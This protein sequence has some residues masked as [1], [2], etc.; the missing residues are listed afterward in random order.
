MSQKVIKQLLAIMLGMAMIFSM[1][2][3]RENSGKTED[4][5]KTEDSA[6]G[7]T[8][9]DKETDGNG[10]QDT[11]G[12]T[13]DKTTNGGE[14]DTDGEKQIMKEWDLDAV[15]ANIMM[16]TV[17]YSHGVILQ[18]EKYPCW[19]TVAMN[20]DT[21]EIKGMVRFD[22]RVYIDGDS[23]MIAYLGGGE[24]ARACTSADYDL[25]YIYTV[26]VDATVNIEITSRVFSEKSDG[27]KVYAY[28]NDP[29]NYLVKETLVKP[30]DM[31]QQFIN[32]LEVKKGDKLY[33]GYNPNE[34]SN[35]DEG[36]FYIKLIYIDV[37]N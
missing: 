26:P 29:S 21:G 31:N 27:F 35:E 12:D 9:A 17:S 32:M 23:E 4:E 7:E 14:T 36:N 22:D 10:E 6:D 1:A 33:F 13:D 24:A 15:A 2:A 19:D 3:C 20:R 11:D 18:P 34:S 8:D 37:A 5:Q 30:K 25:M 28:M 16:G